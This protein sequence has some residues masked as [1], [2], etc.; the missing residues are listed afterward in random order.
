VARLM[1]NAAKDYAARADFLWA[2]SKG[3][4]GKPPAETSHAFPYAGYYIMRSGWQNDALWALF[5]GG[6]FGYGHQHEDKL[7][8]L[9]HAYGRLLLTEGGNYAYD[10]S[11]MRRYVLSTR[12]HNTIRVNGH[13]QNRGLHYDR[14]AFDI[15]AIA[16]ANWRTTREY[17]VVEAVYDE[18]YGLGVSHLVTHRRKVIFLKQGRSGLGPCLVV[19]DRLSPAS[20]SPHRYQALWHLNTDTAAVDGVSVRSADAGQ[21]NLTI[22]PAAPAGLSA[23]VV[24]AQET[25][26]FQGW[27]GI[28]DHQQGEY[29]PAPTAV[30]EWTASGPLRVVTV[31]YPTRAGE[32]CPI[33][34]VSAGAAIGDTGVHI[35]LADGRSVDLDEG[36]FAE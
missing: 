36:E 17:D 10:D 32:S 7:N 15:T 12:A 26:E 28:K 29:E 33:A 22:V 19:I 4:Q 23:T 21:P 16:G 9:L 5:D 11:A 14:S 18:G 20:G 8:L 35:T 25:P 24:C 6:P 3:K 27:V 2:Y 1:S 30:Y 13:D 31:L 34:A